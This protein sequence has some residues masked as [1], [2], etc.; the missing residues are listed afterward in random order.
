MVPSIYDADRSTPGEDGSRAAPAMQAS[1]AIPGPPLN[2]A[3]A[4]RTSQHNNPSLHSTDVPLPYLDGTAAQQR[5]TGSRPFPDAASASQSRQNGAT[6]AVRDDEGQS[7]FPLTIGEQTHP[8]PLPDLVPPLPPPPAHRP[9]APLQDITTSAGHH[10][11][12]RGRKRKH[13]GGSSARQGTPALAHHREGTSGTSVGRP[14]PIHLLKVLD[15]MRTPDD[16]DFLPEYEGFAFRVADEGDGKRFMVTAWRGEGGGTDR[17]PVWVQAVVTRD[18]IGRGWDMS[19]LSD[20]LVAVHNGTADSDERFESVS[21]A[22]DGLERTVTQWKSAAGLSS[23]PPRVNDSP[24]VGAPGPSSVTL[25]AAAG[26]AAGGGGGSADPPHNEPPDDKGLWAKKAKKEP[27]KRKGGKTAEVGKGRTVIRKR[28]EHRSDVPGVYW[29]EQYQYWAASWYDKGDGKQKHKFFYMK[30]HGFD[31]AKALA[32]QHRREMEHTG[33]A[34]VRGRLEHQSGVKG[35]HYHEVNNSWKASWQV[36]GRR[37]TKSFSVKELGFEE[38][39]DAAIAHRQKMERV[40]TSKGGAERHGD[41]ADWR[42]ADDGDD[43]LPGRQRRAPQLRDGGVGGGVP[44]HPTARRD[45]NRPRPRRGGRFDRNPSPDIEAPSWLREG[46]ATPPTGHTASRGPRVSP[47]QRGHLILHFYQQ[48]EALGRAHPDTPLCLRFRS[49]SALPQLAIEVVLPGTPVQ[50]VPL[51]AATR[52]AMGAAIDAAWACRQQEMDMDGTEDQ[53]PMTHAQ[54]MVLCRVFGQVGHNIGA[55]LAAVPALSFASVD[56]FV[57]RELPAMVGRRDGEDIKEAASRFIKQLQKTHRQHTRLGY[58]AAMDAANRHKRALME[59]RH[60]TFE[61]GAPP[62]SGSDSSGSRESRNGSQRNKQRRMD[63]EDGGLSPAPDRYDLGGLTGDALCR[64]LMR[65]LRQKQPNVHSLCLNNGGVGVTWRASYVFEA[66]FWDSQAAAAVDLRQFGVGEDVTSREAIFTAFRQAVEYRNALHSSRLGD[67]AVL[68]DLSWL[69]LV[70]RRQGVSRSPVERHGG[71]AS[72]GSMPPPL[73]LDDRDILPL[74]ERGLMPPRIEPTG[75]RGRPLHGRDGRGVGDLAGFEGEE[76]SHRPGTKRRRDMS[77]GKG[78]Q[79]MSPRLGEADGHALAASLVEQT[80]RQLADVNQDDADS[81]GLEWRGEEGSFVAYRP[82]GGEGPEQRV[83][84]V[85]D[86]TSPRLILRAFAQAAHHLNATAGNGAIVVDVWRINLQPQPTDKHAVDKGTSSGMASM[87]PTHHDGG[88]ADVCDVGGD[89]DM[90]WADD[91]SSP[92]E[93]PRRRATPGKAKTFVQR[94]QHHSDVTGVYWSEKY[95]SWVATWY[96]KGDGKQR[97]K[98]FYVKYHGFDEAKELAEHHRLEMER[99]G[100]AVVRRRAK[101]QSGIKGVTF[102]ERYK[103][104]KAS[105]R[106]GGKA[107]S[108]YF[109]VAELGFEGAKQAAIAHSRAMEERHY[110]RPG[111][112]SQPVH[113]PSPHHSAA[114]HGRAEASHSAAGHGRAEASRPQPSPPAAQENDIDMRGGSMASSRHLGQR[115]DV[116]PSSSPH[117]RVPPTLSPVG[118]RGPKPRSSEASRGADMASPS[119]SEWQGYVTSSLSSGGEGRDSDYRD[120]SSSSP[121]RRLL[122]K[123][124]SRHSGRRGRRRVNTDD[125]EEAGSAS[126]DSVRC[127]ECGKGD[128]EQLL[129]LC[130][131]GGCSAAYHTYCVQLTA[132]PKGKWFCPE[133]THSKRTGTR[134]NRALERRQEGGHCDESVNRSPSLKHRRRDPSASSSPSTV[135]RRQRRKAGNAAEATKGKTAAIRKGAEHQSTVVG[136]SWDARA[137]AWRSTWYAKDDTTQKKKLFT[138]REHGFD[139][140]KV[141]ETYTALSKGAYGPFASLLSPLPSGVGR[142]ASS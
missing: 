131:N 31:K 70:A 124:T 45:T 5:E 22:I 138:V 24:P 28:G 99:S 36:G 69:A 4:M 90:D 72:H 84:S 105:W 107:K 73:L 68:I 133:C 113:Q 42:S 23:V 49:G 100:Q 116:Q 114:G 102:D 85:S 97:E 62:S 63:E 32:E 119:E 57:R 50:S 106:V 66:Y 134:G 129:L 67:Q 91:V 94:A 141:R 137:R 88:E 108:K 55:M 86:V 39:K 41:P 7:A 40:H 11:P 118:R 53:Q 8:P 34:A 79:F 127:W 136:V 25:A 9:A 112:G 92:D 128:D 142:A 51:S 26:A 35:V 122:P 2:A 89:D 17:P 117:R 123:S 20:L 47:V 130:D 111:S 87:G 59:Q 120:S 37:K 1:L 95:Q 140:A 80:R 64:G 30:H 103:R 12:P 139:K 48:L 52:E 58:E 93:Q 13:E 27:R 110:P 15:K 82:D 44:L 14:R 16:R 10:T 115:S 61:R 76:A 132:V 75:R 65:R 121:P 77:G 46:P 43:S 60:S 38:A 98:H 3:P 71:G 125:I 19:M 81:F 6:A 104:W 109:S 96:D 135:E 18:H 101:H 21:D 54:R 78:R 33:Q 29:S 56:S 83:F 74:E 126:D